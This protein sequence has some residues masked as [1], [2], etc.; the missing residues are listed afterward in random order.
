MSMKKEVCQELID[1]LRTKMAKGRGDVEM[2]AEEISDA[3]ETAKDSAQDKADEESD[4][5]VNEEKDEKKIARP[6]LSIKMLSAIKAMKPPTSAPVASKK[7]IG[8]PF[9]KIK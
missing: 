7:P 2:S 1:Y 9:A 8:K 4:V 5:A 6:S 3:V